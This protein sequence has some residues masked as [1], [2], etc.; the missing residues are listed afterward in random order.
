MASLSFGLPQAPATPTSSQFW[1]LSLSLSVSVSVPF[2]LPPPANIESS[3]D[4]VDPTE[5]GMAAL[6]AEVGQ[7]SWGLHYLGY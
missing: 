7:R 2:T 4:T 3:S 1:S 6:E 5:W